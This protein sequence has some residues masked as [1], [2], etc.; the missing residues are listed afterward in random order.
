MDI[1]G[2]TFSTIEAPNGFLTKFSAAGE[3]IWSQ[4]I[5]DGTPWHVLHLDSNDNIYHLK[6]TN[7]LWNIMN[8]TEITS[9]AGLQVR[10]SSWSSGSTGVFIGA[11][12]KILSLKEGVSLIQV[13]NLLAL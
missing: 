10:T 6:D 2:G 9:P 12:I 3:M 4:T 8:A 7:S 5:E 13:H 11:Y 1:S